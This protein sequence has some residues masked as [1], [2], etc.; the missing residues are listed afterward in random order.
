MK[1][2]GLHMKFRA[3]VRVVG[4]GQGT[5]IRGEQ[6]D[7]NLEVAM[8]DIQPEDIEL[9][10]REL[11]LKETTPTTLDALLSTFGPERWFS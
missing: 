3:K 7:F 11:N 5:T 4:L 8:S 2:I 6:P 1:V 10:T 9:L